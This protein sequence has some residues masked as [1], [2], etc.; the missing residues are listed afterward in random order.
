MFRSISNYESKILARSW[1]FRLFAILAF[2]ILGIFNFVILVLPDTNSDRWI[3]QSIPSNIAY[4]N[5]LFLNTAQAVVAIFLASDFVKRDNKMDSS[6][7]FYVRPP[8]NATYIFAKIWGNIRVFFIFNILYISM[9]VLFTFMSSQTSIDLLSYAIY[10]TIITVP[11]LVF[12]IALS[13][14]VM[15]ILKN[16]AV[17]FVI[18]LGYIGLTIFYLNDKFYYLFDYMAYNLPMMKSTIVGFTNI[19][20]II[21]HRL[22]YF[23]AGLGLIFFTISIFKR[24]P[25]RPR[26]NYL[27]L[28]P[29][30]FM[31]AVSGYAAFKHISSTLLDSKMRSIY[32]EI[33]N[34]YVFEPK[35]AIEN[36]DIILTQHNSSISAEA[37]ITGIA[38]ETSSVFVF[39][40]NPGLQT[41]DVVENNNS[42]NYQRNQ[43][44]I[45]IDF[46]R[47]ISEGDTVKLTIK[48]AGYID[49]RF[50][51]LDIS[52]E[53]LQ[54]KYSSFVFNIDKQYSF[55]TSDYLLLT[56]ETYWY[57]HPGTSY[58]NKSASWQQSYFSNFM[59][60]VKPL[61][62]LTPLSQADGI[63]DD[64]GFYKF[65]PDF[66][67]QAISL[68]IGNYNKKSLNID[69][70]HYN[71]WYIN[72][73]DYF[74]AAFDSIADT[75]PVLIRNVKSQF[76]RVYK[77]DYPFN[78][79]SIVETPAQFFSYPRAWTQAQEIIQPAIVYFPEKAFR[80]VQ[81]DV[82]E[83]IKAHKRW[84][85]WQGNDI[86]DE[87]ALIRSFNDI[88]NF[89]IQNEGS[90]KYSD[91]GRGVYNLS[92]ETNP[93]FQFPQI[94][95]FCYNIYSSEYSVANRIIELYLQGKE[96]NNYWEREI[97]GISNNEKS[98]LLMEKYSFLDLLN[99]SEHR[100]IFD[101]IIYLRAKLLF[102]DAE[103]NIG[104]STFKDSLRSFLQRNSFNNIPFDLLLS[105][106]E[107]VSNTDIRNK[108]NEWSYPTHLPVYNIGEPEVTKLTIRGQE[109]FILRLRLSNNSDYDGTL[110]I[111]IRVGGLPD[112]RTDRLIKM[113]ARESKQLV[114]IWENE[115]RE[116]EVNTIISG[117]LPATVL[118][119][120]RNI[121]LERGNTVP[122]EGDFIVS[123]SEFNFLDEIIV[124]NED[125]LLF[126]LSKPALAGLLPKWLDKVEVSSFKY[127]GIGWR[128]PVQWTA[129]TNAGYYGKY[130]RSAYVIRG[131]NGSQTATWKI[132]VA[133]PGRY[134]AYYYIYK[135][136]DMKNNNRNDAEYRFRVNY[137][138]TTEDAAIN[139][140]SANEGWELLG[141][142]YFGG[143]T[144][145]ITLTN[146]CRLRLV[147]ADAVKI[148]RK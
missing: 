22:I 84:G 44:I 48:Y 46:G 18:L 103:I 10:F 69:S 11:T 68:A 58:S 114:S 145:S 144:V 79:F 80:F 15:L 86:T 55:Q 94:Y 70:I 136:D 63:E 33:N 26:S 141:S 96:D 98:N 111:N 34:Q 30:I 104:T 76:E 56:P 31:L 120:V 42:L 64:D 83:R 40:L 43:Q 119:P 147:T 123:N 61:S 125:S 13:I 53:L 91:A 81:F 47:K 57:P 110:N 148:V 93:Y 139:I 129:T 130:I 124:D 65:M 107:K 75:I 67:S 54:N 9:V 37:S 117:N 36:Y 24:L 142:Y 62:G 122:R 41:I 128:R 12:I 131:G 52:D 99:L 49:N 85:K 101:N 21:T 7:V 74:S 82:N 140:R 121:Q 118:L 126:V 134:D 51:Y 146:D 127:S 2:V 38:L 137:D 89:F 39:C 100:N 87:E 132:P 138:N 5:L 20:A 106:L 78:T 108:I 95:N 50:C 17:T 27:W 109:L 14:F 102:A 4:F 25:N 1:F 90:H 112:P 116:I 72:R 3:L 16:Q 115:P 71:I 60:S 77:L 6:E 32:I 92:I 8:S 135:T 59:L 23:F 97:N 28:V 45:L 35:M 105:H 66:Q 113:A 73:H 29:G 143:D 133:T 88:I 19:S